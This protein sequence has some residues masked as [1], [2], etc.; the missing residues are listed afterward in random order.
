VNDEEESLSSTLLQPD[1]RD[2][3]PVVCTSTLRSEGEDGGVLNG[4]TL[5]TL[6]LSMS[7]LKLT[8]GELH[9]D[10]DLD[11]LPLLL[12]L[13]DE[14]AVLDLSLCW[15]QVHHTNVHIGY[16]ETHEQPDVARIE[17]YKN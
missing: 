7:L 5:L 1:C 12:L 4:D 11:S 6:N 15:S 13:P 3:D 10:A 14:S 8:C 17:R 9:A 16:K 2:D